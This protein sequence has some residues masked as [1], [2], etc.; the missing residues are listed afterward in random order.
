MGETKDRERGE[1]EGTEGK[2]SP[3]SFSL[4]EFSNEFFCPSK[5]SLW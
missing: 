2:S 3:L 1:G 4:M 5:K